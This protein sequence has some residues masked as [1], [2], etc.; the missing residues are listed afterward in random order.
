MRKQAFA[1][2]DRLDITLVG[3]SKISFMSSYEI[4][5]SWCEDETVVAIEMIDVHECDV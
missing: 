2:N 1:L 3:R 4:N 5:I